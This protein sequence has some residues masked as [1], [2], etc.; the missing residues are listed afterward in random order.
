[1]KNLCFV[2]L[3]IALSLPCVSPAVGQNE[4]KARSPAGL[5]RTVDDKTGQ[6]KGEVR[7]F[8]RDGHW[9]GQIVRVYDSH[10]A[11]S[12]CDRCS[13]ERKGK[14]ILG[15]IILR[16][17]SPTQGEYGG[18]DILDPDTGKV[19][20]CKLRVAD[21]GEKLDVRGFIGFSMLGRTQTWFRVH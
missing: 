7:I 16:E 5:W 20:R 11:Q 18:G 4:A 21:N 8:E 17:M 12:R 1:M 19:Y 14:E 3:L 15:L 9:F 2:T 13:D 6:P 10:D